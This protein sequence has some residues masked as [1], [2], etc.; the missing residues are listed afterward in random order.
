VTAAAAI[1]D[2][3]LTD[4]RGLADATLE[5]LAI[6]Q[7]ERIVEA[8]RQFAQML[9][10]AAPTQVGQSP[11]RL[12]TVADGRPLT[13][14]RGHPVEASPTTPGLED[15]VFEIATH[16]IEYRGRNSVVL[17]VRD[18]T[19]KKRAQQKIEH[20][21]RHDALTDLPNR[22]LLDERLSHTLARAQHEGHSVALMALDLDRFKAVND[23]FGH[24]AGDDI[25]R[26][27]ASILKSAARHTDTVARI[28]G[29]E[30]MIL[31][32][33]AE[34][35]E[36]A[37]ALARR[38][39]ADFAREMDTTK[40]PMAV[41][42]SIGVAIYPADATDAEGLKHGADIALYRVKQTG[43]GNVCFFDQEMDATVRERRDMEHDLRHAVLRHQLHVA[44]QPLVAT[45]DGRVYGYEALLRWTHPE[46]GN[47]TPDVFIPI[48]EETGSIIQLGEW[49]LRE[50][51]RTALEWPEDIILAVNVSAVQFQVPNFAETIAC[52][53]KE[54]GLAPTRLELEITESVLMK[55][56]GAALAAL[57]QIK[58]L[59]VAI[60]MDDFGTG[61]SSLS[62]LQSFPFNKIKIDRSF[63][64]V[65]EDDA[66]A[67]SIIRA[68]V[69]IGKS[70]GL[71]VLAEGVETEAQHRMVHEEGCLHAQGFLFGE[72]QPAA[73]AT[74]KSNV[75]K[76]DI[77]K[78]G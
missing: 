19:D 52:V 74:R 13:A 44:Y 75:L 49:V 37:Q 56:R 6:I 22:L 27:V 12:L 11:E 50:A 4:L 26:R 40:D 51:C 1:L 48:A 10:V 20:M 70:L 18:L 59:G 8:N 33:G 76:T 53:L 65:L 57:H 32:V 55:D 9:G 69:G 28:G 45:G 36:G 67:R 61:Y 71:P 25:L 68:I 62:N 17:A 29:D 23:I 47:I 60:V 2:R 54:V 5:G 3:Y 78:A 42:V 63:V 14:L 16:A 43:R 15:R 30:F 35:P 64:T 31:Q 41:G 34:Q 24:A 77:R 58:A 38:I 39:I 72:A 66:T 73:A 7:G 21:A 46:R